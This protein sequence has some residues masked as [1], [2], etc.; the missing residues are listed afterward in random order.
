MNILKLDQGVNV[1]NL[2]MI[3]IVPIQKKPLFIVITVF[4]EGNYQ[5]H[6]NDLSTINKY[7]DVGCWHIKYK[8]KC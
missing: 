7:C 5:Y 8:N 3:K 2:K 6:L 1:N 4:Q